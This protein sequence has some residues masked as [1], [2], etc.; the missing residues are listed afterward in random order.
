MQVVKLVFIVFL[1][2]VSSGCKSLQPTAYFFISNISRERR[3]VDVK[4]SIA[5][6]TVLND[7]ILYTGV[8]PDLSNTP[9]ISLPKG[10][11]TIQVTADKGQT[12][13]EQSIVLQNDRWI[14]ISYSF[15][16]PIDTSHAKML[17]QEFRGDTAS[18]HKRLQ[19]YPPSVTIHVM[20]KEPGHM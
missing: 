11:Y 6:N 20:D 9:Y 8:Q 5:G 18:V 10:K 7:P 17:I 15:V 4:V 2:F 13:A 1:I 3:V 19:G 14:Y 12:I 16:L